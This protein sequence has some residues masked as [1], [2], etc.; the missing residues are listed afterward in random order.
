MLIHEAVCKGHNTNLV[1][2][3]EES[4]HSAKRIPCCTTQVGVIEEWSRTQDKLRLTR[5]PEK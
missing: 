4:V 1:G 3:S 2:V 5:L